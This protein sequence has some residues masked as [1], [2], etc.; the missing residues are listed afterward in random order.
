[1]NAKSDA[2]WE[3]LRSPY[4]MVDPKKIDI[5]KSRYWNTVAATLGRTD[6]RNIPSGK[7]SKL[8]T[9]NIPPKHHITSD[10]VIHGLRENNARR[11]EGSFGKHRKINK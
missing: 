4:S 3:R 7:G 9:I 5:L 6:L 2:A 8:G 1:M 10:A 11:L